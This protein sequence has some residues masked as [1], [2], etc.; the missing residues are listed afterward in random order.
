MIARVVTSMSDMPKDGNS[1]PW[2]LGT[3]RSKFSQVI[4]PL[5]HA[6]HEKRFCYKAPQLWAPQLDPPSHE[7][8]LHG[9]VSTPVELE[10]RS[11]TPLTQAQA[12]ARLKPNGITASSTGGCTDRYESL[13]QLHTFPALPGTHN[14]RTVSTCTSYQGILSGTVDGVITLK[15]ASGSSSLVITGGT[16]VGHAS[17][18]YSHANGYKVDVRHATA[19]DNYIHNTFTRIANRGDGYPQW[20]AASGNIYC[21][22]AVTFQTLFAAVASGPSIPQIPHLNAKPY[23]SP[24]VH[25]IVYIDQPPHTRCCMA[26][27][28][29]PLPFVGERNRLIETSVFGNRGLVGH[30]QSFITLS[31]DMSTPGSFD[32]AEKGIFDKHELPVNVTITGAVLTPSIS[33]SDKSLDSVTPA[34]IQPPPSKKPSSRKVSLWIRGQ[35]WFNTYRKFFTFVI[36]LNI[37]GIVLAATGK[38]QYPRYY[39]GAC[40]LGN[41]LVAILMR[42]ELFGRFLYLFVNT[43]FAK[44]TPLAFRLGCTSA[45]QHLGGIHSGCAVSGFMWLIFRVVWIFAHHNVTH[46][47]ILVFGLLTLVIINVSII[48]A[49]PWVRNTHHNVFERHHRFMGWLGVLSTWIFVILGDSWDTDS[50]SW[51][52]NGVHIVR[53]QDFWFVLGMTIF[54]V[55]PWCTIREVKVDVEIPSPKVVV[56]RFERGMQQGLLARISR[57]TIMEYHAF[58]IISEGKRAKHH[59]LICG[60]QGDFTR[61]LVENPPDRI[62]TRQ[63]KASS[64]DF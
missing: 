59:Y 43:L 60:V 28:S 30:F 36:C 33:Q 3:L 61:S 45:L 13:N 52:P 57:G 55:I 26:V 25:L 21:I 41:L 29:S 10:A 16:E 23:C 34:P 2:R 8:L 39:S 56:M 35:L 6:I 58:G 14:V 1:N 18:T 4:R 49:L 5:Y 38:W 19:V 64:C 32:D 48:S 40:V 53:Q 50:Q 17:G 31:P 47:S 24:V 15:Q 42:N 51:N 37:V 27:F 12:E 7:G 44:W 54:V 9:V 63:L 46:T 22:S 62:W 11:G 20:Q